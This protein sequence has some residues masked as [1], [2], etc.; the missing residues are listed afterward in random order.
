[1]LCLAEEEVLLWSP[2]MGTLPSSLVVASD[3]VIPVQ[4]EGVVM[5]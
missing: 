3:Q 4:F 5:A 1:M 2:G